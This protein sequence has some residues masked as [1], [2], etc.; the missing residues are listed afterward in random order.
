MTVI[1]VIGHVDANGHLAF[2]APGNLPPGEVRI[3][4]ETVDAEA[5]AAD[6]A[7]WNEQFARSQDVLE[8]LADEALKDQD[9]GRT[10]E[11]D[12]DTL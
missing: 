12:P 3:I 10:D 1:E 5:E 7:L 6:E 2:E 11:L 9:E 4:I 8:R